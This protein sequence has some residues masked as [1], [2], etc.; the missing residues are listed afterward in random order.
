MTLVALAHLFITLTRRELQE[1]TPE[2]TPDRVV[3]LLWSAIER[4]TLSVEAA[5]DLVN[6]QINRNRIARD[7]HMKFWMYRHGSRG[8]R[9]VPL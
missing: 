8:E 9:F 6:Y 5:I 1:K 7:S 3:R 4:P 2:L